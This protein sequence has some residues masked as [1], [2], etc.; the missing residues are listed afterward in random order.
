MR[1]SQKKSDLAFALQQRQM[2]LDRDAKLSREKAA[3]PSSD[4]FLKAGG[5]IEVL[6]GVGSGAG[7]ATPAWPGPVTRWSSDKGGSH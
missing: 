7:G 2:I 4:D 6:P 5:T 3:L 1:T